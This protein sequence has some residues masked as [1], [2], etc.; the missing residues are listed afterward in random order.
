MQTKTKTDHYQTI[1][2]AM[3]ALFAKG[4]KPWSKPWKSSGADALVSG[5]PH[6]VASGRNYRGCNVPL[7]WAAAT[8]SGYATHQ[9]LTFNQAKALGGHVRKGER[10]TLVV[11]WK[12]LERTERGADGTESTAHI[13]L[14][15]ATP[16]F[17]VAQCEGVRLPK[18][19]RT[20]APADTGSDMGPA[21]PVFER[22]ALA[23][24]LHH[25]GGSADYA[26]GRDSVQVPN[27]SAFT[28]ID[29]YRAVLLHEAAHATGH[30]SRLKRDHSGRFGSSE[31]AFEELVA[32]MAS[33]FTCAALGV[34]SDLEN[35]ASYLDHWQKLLTD[36]R[37][38]FVKACSLAQ[39][40][41]DYLLPAEA[42]EASDEDEAAEKLKAA[43]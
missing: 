19:E 43:A 10:S 27:A 33:A 4:T 40:A 36:H 9:W 24:G 22:L 37:Q 20:A 29:A 16:V 1:T 32:E 3:L 28:S 38:A 6:N 13:P 26:P 14:L 25:D 5:L 23:G 15:R 39:Q 21:A 34:R 41:A 8:A 7:L 2:D 11:F 31:Y 35:H 12:V 30:E 42:A 18:R 17:N